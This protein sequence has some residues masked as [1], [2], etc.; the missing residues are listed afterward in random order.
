M[1]SASVDDLIWHERE[2]QKQKTIK[3][4]NRLTLGPIVINVG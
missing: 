1:S 2:Q 3:Q 4:I